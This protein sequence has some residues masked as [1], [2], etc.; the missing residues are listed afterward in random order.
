[1]MT[2]GEIFANGMDLPGKG[3]G[4]LGVIELWGGTINVGTARGGLVMYENSRI[5]IQDEGLMILEGDQTATVTEYVDQDWIIAYDGNGEVEIFWDGDFTF[6][7]AALSLACDFD[8]NQICDL[9]DLDMLLFDALG[10]TDP[11]FDLDGSGGP[12]DLADRDEW[13]LLAGAENGAQYVLGDSNLEGRVDANDLNNVALNWLRTD[14]NSWQQGDFNG[15]NVVNASDLNDLGVNWLHGV[16][17]ASAVPE[18]KCFLLLILGVAGMF[19]RRR[20]PRISSIT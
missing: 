20:H 7:S 9:A 4:G 11:S 18:P 13:L 19:A 2:G 15:D 5:N 17:A 1:M 14:A 16:A 8:S 3:N 6:V 10:T 12:I